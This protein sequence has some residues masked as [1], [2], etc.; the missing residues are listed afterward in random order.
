MRQP[1]FPLRLLPA[2]LASLAALTLGGCVVR[3]AAHV[4][5]VPVHATSWTVD[6]MTTSQ[7]EA[8]R[9]RGRE[10]RKQEEREARERRR[11]QTQQG[12]ADGS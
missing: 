7:S 12:Y 4:A 8:D 5:M 3:T 1:S 6:K 9:N 11:E 2:L 10:M